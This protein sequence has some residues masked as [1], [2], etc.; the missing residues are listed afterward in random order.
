MSDDPL[1]RWS[2][3]ENSEWS[4]RFSSTVGEIAANRRV[5]DSEY[6]NETWFVEILL[7]NE[8]PESWKITVESKE[9][10]L[11]ERIPSLLRSC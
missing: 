4:I 9:E 1:H 6:G 3:E 10:L 11:D 2:V 8:D 5:V 7:T